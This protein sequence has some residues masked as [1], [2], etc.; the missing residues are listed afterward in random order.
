MLLGWAGPHQGAWLRRLALGALG[1]VLLEC[2]A[3][4]PPPP[5]ASPPPRLARGALPLSPLRP[6]GALVAPPGRWC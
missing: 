6:H 1:A 2:R 3:R 5:P 4:R